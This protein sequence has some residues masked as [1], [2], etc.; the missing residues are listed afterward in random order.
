[1]SALSSYE[2]VGKKEDISD[3]IS[4]ISNR[5]VAFTTLIKGPVKVNNTLF[6]WQE[7]ALAAPDL[8]NAAVEG[9]TFVDANLTPTV[10][11][12]NYTQ[13]LTKTVNVAETTDVVGTYGR[14]KQIAYEL[15]KKSEEIKIDLESIYLSGQTAVAGSSSVAR[16]MNSFQAQVDASLR[17]A[18]GGAT[19][20][21]ALADIKTA[22]RDLMGYGARIN[23]VLLPYTD[24]DALAG[25]TTTPNG[26]FVRQIPNSGAASEGIVDVVDFTVT[27]YGRVDYVLSIFALST[28]W[29]LFDPAMWEKKVLRPWT[30]ETLAKTSD[31]TRMSIV[32]EYSLA[33][34]NQKASA[35]IRKVTGTN[36]KF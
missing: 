26:K 25:F 5:K 8:N 23:T 21:P 35:V 31:S 9:A 20:T 30:R 7:D 32:G 36:G 16:K 10:M 22:Q 33:H 28:D 17:Y 14:A 29:F 13:I 24:A 6:Q 11:R 1:M 19:T 34:K 27:Q 3:V 18:T 4:N 2:I 12:N 15:G